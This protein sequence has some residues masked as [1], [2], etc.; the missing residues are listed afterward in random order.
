MAAGAIEPF[1]DAGVVVS[2]LSGSAN[3]KCLADGSWQSGR[4]AS[5]AN[6]SGGGDMRCSPAEIHCESGDKA[7]DCPIMVE[8]PVGEFIM[9][10][11]G[12]DKFA[13]DT[14]RPAHEV[15]ISSPFALG[16]FQVT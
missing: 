1:G 14:E 9:G 5:S 6:E 4:G 12:G 15:K 13:N 7:K 16:K 2:S 11:N 8:L 3:Q 10:E